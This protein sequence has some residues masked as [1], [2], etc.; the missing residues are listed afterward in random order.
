MTKKD[1]HGNYTES[2]PIDR[3]LHYSTHCNIWKQCFHYHIRIAKPRDDVCAACEHVLIHQKCWTKSAHIPYIFMYSPWNVLLC[4]LN[5][6]RTM[7]ERWVNP[8]WTLTA[9]WRMIFERWANS[10]PE[11]SAN[12][13]AMWTVNA[14]WTFHSESLGYFPCIILNTKFGKNWITE[15]RN[16]V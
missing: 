10:E 15:L 9:I 7:S 1:I 5:G 8:V 6:E 4:Y 12:A 2:F 3:H 14:R 11:R 13:S 16:F